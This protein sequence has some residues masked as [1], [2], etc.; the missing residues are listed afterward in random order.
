MDNKLQHI[1]IIMD[2]NGRWAQERGLPRLEGHRAGAGQIRQVASAARRLGLKYLTLYAFSTENWRRP[3][4]EV[5][6]LMDLARQFSRDNLSDF[7][8]NGICLRTIGRIADLP[9]A[10]Q[11]SLGEVCEATRDNHALTVILA[12]SYGGRAEIVDA[13]NTILASRP[14]T[15]SI[16]EQEFRQ[17]LYAPDIPDPDL[18]IRTGGEQRLS[19]FLL[20]QLSYA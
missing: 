10:L 8:D 1:A 4:S 2:G 12:L 19:N 18:L 14:S 7:M 11:N 5:Q 15:R 16:T 17:Y 9:A 3:P 20:W 6:G 13:V